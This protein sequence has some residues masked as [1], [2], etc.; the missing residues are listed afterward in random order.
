MPVFRLPAEPVFPPAE[1]A[2]EDGLLAVGGDLSPERLIMAYRMG[3]FPWFSEGQPIL[4]WSPDPR[5]ALEPSGLAVSR[6][7]KRTLKKKAFQITVDTAFDRVVEACA[8][9][10]SGERHG[11]WITPEMIRAYGRLSREGYAHSFEA[12]H[13]GELAGGLYGVCLGGVFFGE[14]MFHRVPDASK[15]ALAALAD[16]AR[17][18]DFDMIDCQTPTGHLARMGAGE[19]SRG[20]FLE[21]LERSLLKKTP[22]GRWTMG[23]M[24]T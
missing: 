10:R 4:W 22:R 1:L 5:M 9:P 11:T 15:A 6:R 23:P 8:G 20:V 19:I 13:E 12:W 17:R 2:R 18:H 16:Y 21:R 14:S 24:E 3:I 7:L